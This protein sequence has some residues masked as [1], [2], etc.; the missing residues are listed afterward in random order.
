MKRNHP[1]RK[2]RANPDIN[3]LKRQAKELLK[4]FRDGDAGAAMVPTS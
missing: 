2:L 1:A 3:Q 4:A